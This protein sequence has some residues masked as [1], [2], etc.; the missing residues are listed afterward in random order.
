MKRSTDSRLILASASPR[1]RELLAECGVA[2]SVQAADVDEDVRPGETPA[3]YVLRVATDKA[4]AIHR[5]CPDHF[6]LGCDTTVVLDEQILGKPAS[7]AEAGTM[8][9]ALSGRA[10]QVLSAVCLSRPDGQMDS[11]V[12][13]TA[14]IFAPLPEAWVQH[15]IASGQGR[16]KAGAYGIQNEAGLWISRIEGSYSGVVGLPLF[17]TAELLRGA[18]LIAS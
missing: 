9:R 15:Y 17:E 18:G 7:D 13:R 11:V 2:F 10:H 5:Q 4:R 6:V 12:S 16:D 8:L 1:R 3:E 14:V